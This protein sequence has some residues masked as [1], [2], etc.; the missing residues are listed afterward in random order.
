M[1]ARSFPLGR[2]GLAALAVPAILAGQIS[3]PAAARSTPMSPSY[4]GFTPGRSYQEFAERARALALRDTLRCNTSRNT[5]QLM[6]CGVAIRDPSDSARFYLSAY[7]LE[8]KIAMLSL[9]DSGGPRLLDRTQRDLRAR[10]GQAHRRERSMWEWTSGRR[11]VRFNW[12]GRGQARW[13]SIT[14][15]DDDVMD[16]IARYVKRPNR[17]AP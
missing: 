9:I 14:L 11:V 1:H 3:P 16:G 7:V 5:A 8:G 4:R 15:R 6:E 13:V 2:L 12:R 17:R 10:F